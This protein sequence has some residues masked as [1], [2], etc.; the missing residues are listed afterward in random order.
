MTATHNTFSAGTPQIAEDIVTDMLVA[1]FQKDRRDGGE[2]PEH[3]DRMRAAAQVLAD[4]VLGPVT[5]A[6]RAI[7]SLDWDEIDTLYRS[8]WDNYHDCTDRMLARRRALLDPPKP[9]TLYDRVNDVLVR[10]GIPRADVAKAIVA[11]VEQP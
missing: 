9:R 4:R 6:E 3:I 2:L 7:A 11:E 5:Q 8:G 1:W 10:Y